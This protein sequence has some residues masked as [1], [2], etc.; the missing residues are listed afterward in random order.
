MRRDKPGACTLPTIAIPRARTRGT[1]TFNRK[2]LFT[3]TNSQ[4]PRVERGLH[5]GL[6]TDPG[7]VSTSLE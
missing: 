1:A 3:M 6:V 5:T 2:N 7:N 4:G